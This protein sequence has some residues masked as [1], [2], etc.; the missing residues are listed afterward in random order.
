MKRNFKHGE[1]YF[2]DFDPQV[3]HEYKKIRPAVIIQSDK[4]L[5]V[6]HLITI[7][8][9]TSNTK[10]KHADDIIVKKN[11]KN[12][13]YKDSIIKVHSITSFDR[14]R[15][16]NKI[17]VIDDNSINAIKKYLGTHFQLTWD[18]S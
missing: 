17:G 18:C 4:Q 9:L 5:K 10:N 16:L 1:I 12:R 7:M 13:L 14:R 11:N 15:F 6:S 2:V 8:P 3:G